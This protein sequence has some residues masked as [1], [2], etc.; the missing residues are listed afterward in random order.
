MS[1]DA[2]DVVA[3]RGGEGATARSPT[4]RVPAAVDGGIYTAWV[5]PM[6]LAPHPPC[7]RAAPC[8]APTSIGPQR[9]VEPPRSVSPPFAL[10]LVKRETTSASATA[11]SQPMKPFSSASARH[12][13]YLGSVDHLPPRVLVE[14][15]HSAPRRIFRVVEEK[16][17]V[18]ML[19]GGGFLH[20]LDTTVRVIGQMPRRH[21]A[22]RTALR[23][24]LAVFNV[25]IQ[26]INDDVVVGAAI[27][28]EEVRGGRP[29]FVAAM[30]MTKFDFPFRST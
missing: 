25:G 14:Y 2:L 27:E 4:M 13:I 10:G 23:S 29:L 21:R 7:T 6:R 8:S 3:L 28:D 30:A 11:P 19:E 20:E 5:P 15:D 24:A 22:R 26:K 9:A 12:M 18:I 16:R 1:H 17:G